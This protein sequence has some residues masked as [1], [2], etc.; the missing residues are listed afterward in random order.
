M[1][2]PKD[3]DA[4][5]EAIA[6]RVRERMQQEAVPPLAVVH[7]TWQDETALKAWTRKVVAR[8]GSDGTVSGDPKPDIARMID[9][10][11]LKPD[12]TRADIERVC[13]EA[14]EYGFASV[15]INTTW[16]PLAVQMLRGS[17]VMAIC[18]VGFPLGA[19]ITNAKAAETRE[20]I[21]LGAAEIDMVVNIGALK[22][23][24][25]DLVLQDIKAVVQAAQGRP[26]KVILETKML[27]REEKVAAC[28]LAKAAGAAFVK[29]S[30]GFGG[31][32]A[33]AEDVALM[34]SIVGPDMGVKASGGVRDEN[35]A[36]NMI[37]AGANRLGASA[38]I[39]IVTG[40]T[41]KGAY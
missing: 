4:L 29:T 12:A 27:S 1:A 24:D 30:T 7:G 3:M 41:G 14:A 40:G 22:S 35:D 32:G 10:T 36:K 8:F 17:R 34:R 9:H 19:A 21:R 28:A 15:C 20:A 26:V 39:A 33:T 5:V 13:R 11:M 25:H 6:A 38:S 23:G 31:G 16:L 18:V 2:D 37:R